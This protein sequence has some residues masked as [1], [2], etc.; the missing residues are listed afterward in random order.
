MVFIQ[1]FENQENVIYKVLGQRKCSDSELDLCSLISPVIVFITLNLLNRK[2]SLCQVL[3]VHSFFR[4]LR[5]FMKAS[6]RSNRTTRCRLI[7][8]NL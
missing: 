8:L 2:L 5:S 4:H 3:F 6:L 1:L 7:S